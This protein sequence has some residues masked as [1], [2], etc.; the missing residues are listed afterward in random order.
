MR[1]LVA[2]ALI[3][4]LS[5]AAPV[6]KALKTKDDTGQLV[7]AWIA[8]PTDGRGQPQSAYTF[9]FDADGTVRSVTGKSSSEWTWTADPTKT[10]KRMRWVNKENPRSSWE[11]V[12]ELSGDTLK[13]GFVVNGQ[14]PPAVIA[15]GPNLT[16]YEMTRHTATK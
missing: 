3:V 10:P 16:V 4:G 8:N 2:L 9:T 6:P 5:P 13:V 12:Y 1:P 15:P 14:A 7:G 11:C